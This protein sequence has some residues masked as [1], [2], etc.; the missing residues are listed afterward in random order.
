MCEVEAKSEPRAACRVVVL[1]F[2]FRSDSVLSSILLLLLLLLASVM[3]YRVCVSV[4]TS[5]RSSMPR[6]SGRCAADVRNIKH[7]A[8]V[9]AA[10]T[11]FCYDFKLPYRVIC[12]IS[13]DPFASWPEHIHSMASVSILLRAQMIPSSSIHWYPIF[14]AHTCARYVHFAIHDIVAVHWIYDYWH[15]LRHQ[16]FCR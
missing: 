9:L 1:S 8:A 3:P 12:A 15:I 2:S 7:I 14:R 4:C 11:S 13:V 10:R 6:N 5:A 16:R